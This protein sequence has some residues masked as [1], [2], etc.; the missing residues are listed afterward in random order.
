MTQAIRNV[1][2][3]IS[4]LNIASGALDSMSNIVIR[5]S[6]LAEQAANGTLSAKQRDSLN[7][8]FQ[9]LALEYSRICATTQFNGINL[10]P[11]AAQT[12]SVHAANSS[13]GIALQ[14]SSA[15][16][17]S[18]DP[19]AGDVSLQALWRLDDGSGSIALDSSA[20]GNQASLVN[21]PTWTTGHSGQAVSFNGVDEYL[22]D[23][24]VNFTGQAVTVSFW[25]NESSYL[26]HSTIFEASNDFNATSTGF[27]MFQS[28]PVTGGSNT[29]QVALKGDVGYNIKI[30]TPPTA[31]WH[32][33]T[34]VF[35]K[36]QGAAGE[37]QLFIDGAL[38]TASSQPYTNDNTNSFGANPFFMCSRAGGAEFAAATLDQVRIF[39]RSL[40]GTEAQSLYQET[41]NLN[42]S[43]AADARATIDSLAAL[44]GNLTQFIGAVGSPETRLQS[45]VSNLETQR[46]EYLSASSRIMD[47]DMAEETAAL[48]RGRLLQQATASILAQAN[49]QPQIA[50][51][52]LGAN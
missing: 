29:L 31:G 20:A 3:G 14:G 30:Y 34:A 23:S 47:A 45:A 5:Q 24:S 7:N 26:T 8:E 39:G 52:L 22:T 21:T 12:I 9:Q 25:M 38:Q 33:Y 43:T 36:S 16:G 48:V 28:D 35:D 42:I 49:L 44:R 11:S 46:L 27:G 13:I 6:E 2:D 37:I 10:L 17:E 51:Q 15:I 50:L 1:N 18:A 4:L 40:S 41:G 32:Q 19:F